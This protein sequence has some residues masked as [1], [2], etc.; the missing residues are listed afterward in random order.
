MTMAVRIAV[1]GCHIKVFERRICLVFVVVVLISYTI[2]DLFLTGYGGCLRTTWLASLASFF[3]FCGRRKNGLRPQKRPDF[4]CHSARLAF[5][6][7]TERDRSK[8][9]FVGRWI[10][11][12]GAELE[13]KNECITAFQASRLRN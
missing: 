4:V 9:G 3:R 1:Y 10:A 8:I 11:D 5:T 7:P 6:T 2:H 12:C 13:V